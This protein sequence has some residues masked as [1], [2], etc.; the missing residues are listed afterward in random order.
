MADFSAIAGEL[1]KPGY[2]PAY[3]TVEPQSD[4]ANL[5]GLRCTATEFERPLPQPR[6]E[7]CHDIRENQ[8]LLRTGAEFS[9]RRQVRA[10]SALPDPYES[11][12]K[13]TKPLHVFLW[14]GAKLKPQ[15]MSWKCG[16]YWP[17]IH[18]ASRI[19]DV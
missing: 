6:E 19:R 14:F 5:Q 13:T 11:N 8:R 3:A 4:L 7:I 10:R 17:S 18:G 1:L 12:S 16:P 15:L 9:P 2:L